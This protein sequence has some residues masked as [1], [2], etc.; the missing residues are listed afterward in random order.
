MNNIRGYNKCPLCLSKYAV[1]CR[2]V[3]SLALQ[4]ISVRNTTVPTMNSLASARDIAPKASHWASSHIFV[5]DKS[6]SASQ[7][8]SRSM[9]T[10]Y[11]RQTHKPY[12]QHMLHSR[13]PRRLIH[14]RRRPPPIRDIGRRRSS[15]HT[16]QRHPQPA[17]P[18]DHKTHLPI[19]PLHGRQRQ[20][21]LL[22]PKRR[23]LQQW[24]NL[25]LCLRQ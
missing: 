23:H 21:Q 6:A 2:P 5:F 9:F 16:R 11:V 24:A 19:I 8:S 4:R 20:F 1:L 10:T 14:L 17:P 25:H 12:N 3:H 13:H 18:I 15:R 7:E 22:H